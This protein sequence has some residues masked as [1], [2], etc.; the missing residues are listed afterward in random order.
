MAAVST[1]RGMTEASRLQA[2]LQGAPFLSSRQLPGGQR[3]PRL[4]L[5]P[6]A[7][8][9]KYHKLAHKTTEMHSPTVLEVR[10]L[11]SR[12]RGALYPLRLGQILP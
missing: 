10:N 5:C 2:P 12:C 1:L 4:N 9:T 6:V 8:V 3:G 7:A 11:K